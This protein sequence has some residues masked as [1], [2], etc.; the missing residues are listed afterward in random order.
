[1]Q[2]LEAALPANL[3]TNVGFLLVSF[4]TERDTPAA[5]KNYRAQHGLAANWT[6]LHGEA[7]DVLDLAALLGVKFKK[8]AQGQFMHSNIITVLNADGEIA[9]QQTRSEERRVGKEC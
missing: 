1:M 9:Y 2:Q 3:R 6:L 8:D 4:D 5:L 7:D